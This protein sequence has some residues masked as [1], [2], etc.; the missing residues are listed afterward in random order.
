MQDNGAGA[1]RYTIVWTSGILGLE[2]AGM[3]GLGLKD[4]GELADI[5]VGVGVGNIYYMGSWLAIKDVW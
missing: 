1:G 2:L 5:W 3:C 4:A